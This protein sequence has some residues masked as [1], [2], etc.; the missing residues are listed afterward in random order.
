MTIAL[1][2]L[3]IYLL[4]PFAILALFGIAW[5]ASRIRGKGRASINRQPGDIAT[6]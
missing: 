6:V 4:S 1:L 2:L 3:V 5:A